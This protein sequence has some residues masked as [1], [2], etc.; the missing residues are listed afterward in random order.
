MYP[1]HK[2]MSKDPGLEV[3]HW[4]IIRSFLPELKILEKEIAL[5]EEKLKKL[6]EDANRLLLGTKMRRFCGIA[7]YEKFSGNKRNRENP[8]EASINSTT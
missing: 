8:R 1:F 2:R 5:V 3:V 7:P 4:E 6:V